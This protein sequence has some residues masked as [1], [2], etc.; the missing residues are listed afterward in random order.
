MV[1]ANICLNPCEKKA[2]YSAKFLISTI[3]CV[4]HSVSQKLEFQYHGER[5]VLGVLSASVSITRYR[6]EGQIE[7]S[8][9]DTVEVG[10]KKNAIPEI[11]QEIAEKVVGWTSTQNPFPPVFEG[12]SH[13]V[14][15]Y[16]VFSL[17]I[18]QKRVPSTL[19][20]KHVALESVKKLNDSDREYLSREEKRMIKDH[21]TNQL[22]RRIP[23]TPSIYDLIWEYE[24][25]QL[26]FF[27]N[28]KGANEVLETL[29]FQSFGLR[30]IR[31][32]P[33]TQAFLAA[34]LSNREKDIL[35]QITP[36]VFSE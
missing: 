15:T 3:Y 23:A 7:E 18:D 21:V 32:F 12:S 29:F 4:I 31:L 17:R 20:Q 27:S 24:S 9:L 25:G 22:Y 33:Y 35:G 1:T 10:L 6:V 30:I 14:G 2:I 16:F 26:R 36:T 8:L 34:G 28:Q 5:I 13:V 19:I 11:D